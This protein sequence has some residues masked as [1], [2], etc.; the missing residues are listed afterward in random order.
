MQ[1]EEEEGVP[2][3]DRQGVPI[4]SGKE[5]WLSRSIDTMLG[6]KKMENRHD[7]WGHSKREISVGFSRRMLAYVDAGR[8][9]STVG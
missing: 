4:R 3:E 1:E 7:D 2:G 9:N 6:I 5:E 8:A